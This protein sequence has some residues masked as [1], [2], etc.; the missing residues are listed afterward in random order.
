[1]YGTFSSTSFPIFL[2]GGL[3]SYTMEALFL[4]SELLLFHS[5]FPS[6]CYAKVTAYYPLSTAQ[7]GKFHQ[8]LDTVRREKK[9][10]TI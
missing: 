10:L 9:G 4:A 5:F 3:C 7:L 1:M 8:Y 2:I 6:N